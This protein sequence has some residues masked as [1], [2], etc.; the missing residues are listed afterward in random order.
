MTMSMT[1]KEKL[2][3]YVRDFP[4]L[5][6]QNDG[7]QEMPAADK[8]SLRP[9]IAELEELLKEHV[10]GFVRFQNFK[11]NREGKLVLRCQVY[12]NDQR[13]FV[14]VSYIPLVEFEPK[15]EEL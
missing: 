15:A 3:C 11:R 6:F 4:K 7:Y 10:W 14:G 13:S 5:V 8:E 9:Q 12:Y 2:E 1:V